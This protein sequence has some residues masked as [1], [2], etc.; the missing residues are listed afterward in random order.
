MRANVPNHAQTRRGD[1]TPVAPPP[2]H[3]CRPDKPCHHI[4]RRG[5]LAAADSI[6]NA[7]VCWCCEC[8]ELVDAWRVARAERDLELSRQT[9]PCEV[10]GQPKIWRTYAH[11]C[12]YAFD[13]EL[14]ERIRA[15]A[16]ACPSLLP[17]TNPYL[18]AD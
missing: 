6:A 13:R 17:A 2:L 9:P 18:E 1:A 5:R 10:C 15:L 7:I 16:A 3:H 4:K 11:V 12:P 8:Q 14:H